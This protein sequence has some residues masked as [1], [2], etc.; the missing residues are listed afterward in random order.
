M[1]KILAIKPMLRRKEI[2]IQ[3]LGF[4]ESG[5]AIVKFHDLLERG[6]Y[7]LQFIKKCVNYLL[8]EI[9]P[10]KPSGIIYEH[11]MKLP[12]KQWFS[13]SSLILPAV[14]LVHTVVTLYFLNLFASMFTF[15][16]TTFF[17]LLGVFYYILIKHYRLGLGGI[18]LVLVPL[19]IVTMLISMTPR[20]HG[21]VFGPFMIIVPYMLALPNYFN[22]GLKIRLIITNTDLLIRAPKETEMYGCFES[23]IHLK[24]SLRDICN[25]S[26]KN[27]GHSNFETLLNEHKMFRAGLTNTKL[28]WV[29][30]R[31]YPSLIYQYI[32]VLPRNSLN[33][34]QFIDL[35]LRDGNNIL[36]EFD[37]AQNF[38][39]ILR[40]RMAK[41]EVE[42]EA[43]NKAAKE[44]AVQNEKEIGEFI[45]QLKKKTWRE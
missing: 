36:I 17:L 15:V 14:W 26:I 23:F 3:P 33:G 7:A 21:V 42:I 37:D 18:L 13:I 34:I 28:S 44:L 12:K 8:E 35:V 5:K 4:Q 25:V 16:E 30:S 9:G 1:L 38:L 41:R 10:P 24:F 40:Q 2:D 43:E 19:T 32:F 6:N 31:L 20:T 22:D 27:T 11:E 45:E 29:H 39:N